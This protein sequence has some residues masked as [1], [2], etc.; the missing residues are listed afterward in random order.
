MPG[1]VINAH[2]Y[3]MMMM[4]MTLH[5]HTQRENKADRPCLYTDAPQTLVYPSAVGVIKLQPSCT[6]AAEH[7]IAIKPAAGVPAAALEAADHRSAAWTCCIAGTN[8]LHYPVLFDPC[9]C[10][11]VRPPVCASA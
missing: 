2:T 8:K 7:A 1:E 3:M 10:W 9:W 6:Q 11:A 5:T 4:M